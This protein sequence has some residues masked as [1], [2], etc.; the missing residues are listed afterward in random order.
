VTLSRRAFVGRA[1]LLAAAALAPLPRAAARAGLVATGAQ[2]APDALVLETL[3][4]VVAYVVPGD[5]RYSTAQGVSRAQAGGVAARG[6]EGLRATLAVAGPGTVEA[7]VAVLNGLAR[8]VDPGVD[9]RAATLG[10]SA[11]FAA[12]PFAAK[13]EVF[14]R[15][16]RSAEDA[17][18]RLGAILP[19]IAAFVSYSEYGVVG[20]AQPVGWQLTGYEGVADGRDELRGY[21]G[22]RRRAR[23]KRA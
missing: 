19:A 23:A 7:T 17:F 4:G 22:G 14:A 11:P 10:F 5:D 1:A 13:T 18:R 20:D 12:L 15:L 9:A 3:D 21:Y 6:G 8:A 16:S 2:A